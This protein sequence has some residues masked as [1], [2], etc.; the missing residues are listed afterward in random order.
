MRR[1]IATLGA[2][3]LLGGVIGPVASAN[4]SLTDGQFV[5]Y[6]ARCVQQ[7]GKWISAKPVAGVCLLPAHPAGSHGGKPEGGRKKVGPAK[8]CRQNG[9]VWANLQQLGWVCVLGV[10]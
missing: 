4:A 7:G 8:E 5:G 1:L 9:G 6:S 10:S 3:A 2:C